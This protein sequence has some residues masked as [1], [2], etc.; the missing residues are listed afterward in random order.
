MIDIAV[1]AIGAVAAGAAYGSAYAAWANARWPARGARLRVPG[2]RAHV[3]VQGESGPSVVCLHGASANGREFDAV[4]AA[5]DGQARIAVIDRPGYGHSTRPEGAAALDRAAAFVADAMAAAGLGRSIIAAHS[6]G[7]A[8]ALRL[9]LDRP[10]LVAGLVLVAPAACPYPG[11]NA[12]HVRL[13][14]RPLIGP[15]F[16]RVAVPIAGPL[17]ARAAIANTFAPAAPPEGYAARAGVG[18]LFR[19][20]TFR[21]NAQD[22][23]ATKAEFERQYFRYDEIVAPAIIITADADRVV[24]PRIHAEALARALPKAELVVTPGAGHMPHQIRP[25][26]VAAAILRIAETEAGESVREPLRSG[27]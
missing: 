15:V 11:P 25:E 20:K 1:G 23:A 2:G 16:A 12:W 9:A 7:A 6:L 10:D 22:V 26:A 8:T 4:A 18:L 24:S 21:A 13:A 17:M 14:A 27:R 3:H 19:P 5:L